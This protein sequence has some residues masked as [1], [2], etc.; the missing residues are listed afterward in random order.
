MESRETCGQLFKQSEVVTNK[1]IVLN[2]KDV[3]F[4]Y[5][6]NPK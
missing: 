5:L 1:C 2:E 6:Y 3:P 4:D